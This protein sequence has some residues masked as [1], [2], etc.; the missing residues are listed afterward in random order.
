LF[1]HEEL[2]FEQTTAKREKSV[3]YD[4]NLKA[5]EIS[6]WSKKRRNQYENQNHFN[7]LCGN[8]FI[9]A[10]ADFD[11][12]AKQHFNAGRGGVLFNF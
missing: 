9:G 8:R 10:N 6:K 1:V 4:N 7:A 12:F 3:G 2:Y 5:I 11:A